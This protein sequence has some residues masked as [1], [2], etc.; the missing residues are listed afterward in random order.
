M[1]K[2]I[3]YFSLSLLLLQSCLAA[4]GL[5]QKGTFLSELQVKKRWGEKKWTVEQFKNGDTAV[6]A[7]MAAS[8]LRNK[9]L[10][11]KSNAEIFQLLGK[12]D[13]YYFSDIIPAYVIEDKSSEGGEVWQIVLFLDDNYKVVNIR[14]HKNGS[15]L[16]P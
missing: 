1:I 11:G 9:E 6:R 12:R 10:I 14:V 4:R 16:S 13:G 5:Q 15:E 8:M 7:S 3:V 2:Q